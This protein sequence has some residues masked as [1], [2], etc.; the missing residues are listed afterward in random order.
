MGKEGGQVE[1]KGGEDE[2]AE[3]FPFDSSFRV[4]FLGSIL[5]IIANELDLL[6]VLTV[7]V[8]IVHHEEGRERETFAPNARPA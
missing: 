1:G 2:K 5:S 7:Q 6:C 3:A 8:G 4:S